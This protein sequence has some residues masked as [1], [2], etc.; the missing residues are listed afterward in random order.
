MTSVLSET[1]TSAV[2]GLSR[3]PLWATASVTW[4]DNLGASTALI[5]VYFVAKRAYEFTPTSL[6]LLGLLQGVT[7]I[8]AALA[9]GPLTRAL[10]GRGRALSTRGLLSLLHVV[11][12]VVCALPILI[13]SPIAMWLVVGLYAP[14]TGVLWPTIESFLSAGRMGDDLRR[15]SGIFNLS[16]ASCQVVTF[17][18]IAA[19]MTEPGTAL[20]AIP[21]MGLSH[22]VAIPIIARFQRE[23]AA[24]GEAS[25]AHS[26]GEAALF[27]RLLAC[28]RLLLILSYVVFAAL[29]P[30][31]PSIMDDRLRIA[32]VWATP[33]TSA[34]MISRVASFWFMGTWGGWH[35]RF[36]TLIWPPILLLTGMGAALLAPN[37]WALTIGLALFGLG[38]G[39]IYASAFYYAMEV[40]SAGV[41]AGGRHE[42]L[43]G[44]GYA[45]G[46]ILGT[47][48]GML[49]GGSSDPERSPA[50]FTFG[51][52]L[53]CSLTFAALMRRWAK[54]RP[55]PHRFQN[56]S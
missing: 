22:L 26:P 50:V 20:W 15:S 2:A 12:A 54:P 33:I 29:N 13:R 5:G 18:S 8:V 14:L 9:A 28:H 21:V 11:L 48:A 36:T 47:A 49:S 34:W 39:A 1:R 37:A 41:D 53:L 55:D 32:A 10:A 7:Y 3:S 43:I 44:V 16:W 30:L 56:E 19:F 27:K 17:W 46:P 38:M 4:I 52:V 45:I 51:L 24:H 23:P 6:L 42:A 25:H 31:L 35:G 40:G